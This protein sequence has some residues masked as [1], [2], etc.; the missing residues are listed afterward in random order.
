MISADYKR[1]T[2][3]AELACGMS[4]M[5]FSFDKIFGE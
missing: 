1:Q 3:Y 5:F 2:L 4:L